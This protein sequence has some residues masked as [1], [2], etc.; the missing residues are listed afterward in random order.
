[1]DHPLYRLRNSLR[2][3]SWAQHADEVTW[4][5]GVR[6]EA[7]PEKGCDP[8]RADG[9]GAS[10]PVLLGFPLCPAPDQLCDLGQVA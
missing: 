8:G 7:P 5:T 6:H 2:E 9:V 3:S 1:M 4:G 10:A